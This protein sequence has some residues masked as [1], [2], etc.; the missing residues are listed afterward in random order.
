MMRTFDEI[1]MEVQQQKNHYKFE[2]YNDTCLT[3]TGFLRFSELS[4]LKRSDSI[5][6]KIYI[7]IFI[8]KSKIDI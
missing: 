5:L 2:T 3:F 4:N 8:Q 6:L 1:F 7:S